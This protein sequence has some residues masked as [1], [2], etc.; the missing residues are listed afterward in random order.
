MLEEAGGKGYV[1]LAR[2]GVNGDDEILVGG[3]DSAAVE[4]KKCVKRG[5]IHAFYLSYRAEFVIDYFVINQVLPGQ[6][7]FVR[8]VRKVATQQINRVSAQARRLLFRSNTVQTD[9]IGISALLAPLAQTKRRENLIQPE[10]QKLR[11]FGNGKQ[12]V[13][14]DD[15]QF[16][17]SPVGARARSL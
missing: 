6:K 4:E 2:I 16:P 5:V 11:V 7:R 13:V 8:V 9:D 3:N 14:A 15:M 17:S 10:E 1:Q 12:V